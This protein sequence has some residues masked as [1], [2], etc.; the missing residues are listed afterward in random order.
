MLINVRLGLACLTA[1]MVV[2]LL[3]VRLMIRQ[4]LLA[5]TLVR[6]T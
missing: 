1:V 3:E 2:L 6:L 4:F 5:S